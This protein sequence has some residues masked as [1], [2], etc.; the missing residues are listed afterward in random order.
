VPALADRVAA[1][2]TDGVSTVADRIE[3]VL[4]A[5]S[6]GALTDIAD[7]ARAQRRR[8][9]AQAVEDEQFVV[10][11]QPIASLS[12]L[13]VVSF[14]ALVFWDHPTRGMLPSEQY[15]DIARDLDLIGEIAE[16]GLRKTCEVLDEWNSPRPDPRGISINVLD[17]EFL[18]A[19]YRVSLADLIRDVRADPGQITL[20]V[21][22]LSLSHFDDDG[23]IFSEV[24]A[25][26]VNLAVDD[27]GTGYSSLRYMNRFPLRS[28][29]MAS[30]FTHGL[31]PADSLALP[32]AVIDLG[33]NLGLE[34]IALGVD[35]AVQLETL[36]RL[37]CPLGQG[38]LLSPPL[39]I[40][41]ASTLHRV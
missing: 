11:L 17:R 35:E 32:R 25:M 31:G 41:E 27:F 21:P 5:V 26:G 33:L 18:D 39:T 22:E 23:E 29:K 28:L 10:M 12:D 30:A 14:E 38:D 3:V 9:L 24:V 6:P 16:I 20:E 19:R 8:E 7:P 34:I 40:D 4:R 36:D 1:A 2:S 37:R 15:L 13:S